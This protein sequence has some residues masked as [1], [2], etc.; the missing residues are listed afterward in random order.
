MGF[1]AKFYVVAAG[2]DAALW[3]PVIV[4][5]IGSVIGLFYYLRIVAVMCALPE[6]APERVQ[7]RAPSGSVESGIVLAGLTVL[8]VVLGVYPAA[9]IRILQNAL[10]G[11]G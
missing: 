11:F 3:L 9:L 6:G 8:L 1:I 4:L 5:V 10:A 2:I 7:S